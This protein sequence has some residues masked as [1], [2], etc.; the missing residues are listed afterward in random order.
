[1][2]FIYLPFVPSVQNRIG[3]PRLKKKTFDIPALFFCNSPWTSTTKSCNFSLFLHNTFNMTDFSETVS[4]ARRQQYFSCIVHVL[5]FLRKKTFVYVYLCCYSPKRF[6][7]WKENQ[8][9]LSGAAAVPHYEEAYRA[10]A[11]P[12]KEAWRKRMPL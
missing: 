3:I 2:T 9:I 12:T 5:Y 7:I 10:K 11:Q 1:M 6:I 4:E 8:I